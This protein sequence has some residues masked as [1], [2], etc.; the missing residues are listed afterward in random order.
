MRTL[1]LLGHPQSGGEAFEQ[2]MVH[3]GMQKASVSQ[4]QSM[5]PEEIS[6]ALL[7][8]A[9]IKSDSY[10]ELEP[11]DPGLVWRDLALDLLLANRKKLLWG[12]YDPNA[13]HFLD[14]WKNADSAVEFVLIF[15]SPAFAFASALEFAGKAEDAKLELIKS[16]KKYNAE[17][18][19]F[20]QRNVERCHWIDMDSLP[21][22][23]DYWV[24]KLL[25]D[26]EGGL[27]VEAPDK[28]PSP[29]YQLLALDLLQDYSDVRD[30]YEE[31]QSLA[32]G[33]SGS[34]GDLEDRRR[35]ASQALSTLSGSASQTSRISDGQAQ[36]L[37][38]ENELLLLQL[39][40]VQEELEYYFLQSQGKTASH[41]FSTGFVDK[42]Q[43]YG[44]EERVK[45]ML[46]YRLGEVVKCQTKSLWGILSLPWALLRQ[47]YE[48]K[49]Y[50]Q[51]L[52]KQFV[53]AVADYADAH[54]GEICKQHL[55]F[56]LG[57]VVKRCG[58]NPFFFFVLP[59]MLRRE[60]KAFYQDKGGI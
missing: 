58:K 36:E 54:E 15:S 6:H 47:V 45:N 2:L 56:R 44:A 25:K 46:S 33:L 13:V 35:L 23:P 3:A 53:P 19:R 29:L 8:R 1:I 9:G 57:E 55:S 14:Y 41:P 5:S 24:R 18:L 51:F 11:H 7:E 16:W 12:W 40:Q 30:L 49:K 4:R 50:Q 38:E 37:R 59:W 27:P 21:V 28:R 32:N 22:N 10:Q 26:A 39:H 43:L 52:F 20:Y 17:L 34:R 48:F 60:A 42:N 31:I